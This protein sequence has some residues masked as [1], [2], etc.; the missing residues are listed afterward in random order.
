MKKF[1]LLAVFVT[2]LVIFVTAAVNAADNYSKFSSAFKKNFKDC[3]KYQ[4]TVNS[5]YEGENFTSERSIQGWRN[6]F[7]RYEEI[8]SS[9]NG[10]YKVSCA[11]SNVQVDELYL[12]MKS[13]SKELIKHE[14]DIFVEDPEAKQGKQAKYIKSGTITI[15]GDLPYIT[16]AKYQNN[17]YFCKPEKIR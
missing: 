10:A 6:G 9:K 15:K 3:D 8:I 7:C 11:F 14:L 17:P 2:M 16:W 5:E 12:A 13:R 1:T 4:E